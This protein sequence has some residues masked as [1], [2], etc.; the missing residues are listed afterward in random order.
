MIHT[1]LIDIDNTLLDFD[2]C[3]EAS[4]RRGLSEL[5]IP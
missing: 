4:I 1:I 2:R 5:G 3:A